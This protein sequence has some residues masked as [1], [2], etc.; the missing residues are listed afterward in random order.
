V[1]LA[2]D[3]SDSALEATDGY[4]AM[5]VVVALPVLLATPLLRRLATDEDG[6]RT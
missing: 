4:A 2:I 5:W 6:A 1:G 3:L